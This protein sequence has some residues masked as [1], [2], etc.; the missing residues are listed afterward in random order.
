MF[1]STMSDLVENLE[2]VIRRVR[3]WILEG[4]LPHPWSEGCGG[5]DDAGKPSGSIPRLQSRT[6][7]GRGLKLT[8]GVEH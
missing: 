8:M 6:N 1:E 7:E 3:W 2:K 5:W 4:T